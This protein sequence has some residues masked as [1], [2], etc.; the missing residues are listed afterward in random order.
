MANVV[1]NV[2]TGKAKASGA[3]HIAPTTATMPTNASDALT[4]FTALGYVSEDGL[5]NSNSPDTEVVHAWGGDVVLVKQQTRDD[6]F[7]FSL[8]ESKNAD[9]LKVV[10]GDTK[11]TGTTDITVQATQAAL[12]AHA[13]VFD[14]V[15]REGTLKRIV[16][17]NGVVTEVGDVV[18]VDNDI[19]KYDVTI[20]CLPDA[21]GVTHYEYISN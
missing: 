19:I 20:T 10:Y 15:L 16:V 13:Y 4:G 9:A 8:I 2:S 14:M 18:Y 3:I 6:T 5:T 1:E 21:S 17:P 12:E 7:A 11:V